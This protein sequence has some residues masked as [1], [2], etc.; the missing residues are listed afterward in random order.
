MRREERRGEERRG[1]EKGGEARRGEERRGEAKWRVESRLRRGEKESRQGPHLEERPRSH[2]YFV[3][4]QGI[5][6]VARP[7]ER[8]PGPW[9]GREKQGSDARP[10]SFDPSRL[11]WEES[12]G[13]I[14]HV[15][16]CTL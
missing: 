15:L 7:Q 12:C 8:R 4:V 14:T 9:R 13:G 6:C 2:Q 10:P 3:N 5:P 11:L 1:E 16:Y